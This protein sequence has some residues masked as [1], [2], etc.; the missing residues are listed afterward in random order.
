MSYEVE[1]KFLVAD[2][3]ELRVRLAAHGARFGD[4]VRQV[5]RYFRHPARDF[6]CTDEALRIRQFG[7]QNVLT[8]KGPKLDRDTK[9]RREIELDIAPLEAGAAAWHELLLALGFSP[10]AEVC[11]WRLPGQIAWQGAEV[12]LALDEVAGV[13]S[14]IELE[15]L[16]EQDDLAATQARVRS[17]AQALGLLTMETRSYL[18]MLL[19][20]RAAS[21]VGS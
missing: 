10:V 2:A 21:S 1:M 6:A 15:L 16:A 11:K 12:Q 3:G 20:A 14:F 13:G 9:T 4:A 17:L 7:S 19:A 5:D 18:E 8:Y